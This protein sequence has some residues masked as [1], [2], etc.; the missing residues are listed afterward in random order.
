MCLQRSPRKVHAT[1]TIADAS[2][3]LNEIACRSFGIQFAIPMASGDE[4]LFGIV[5]DVLNQL[6]MK[7][8]VS[9]RLIPNMNIG[10]R[11]QPPIIKCMVKTYV[12]TPQM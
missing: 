3:R 8:P 5:M 12:Q 1:P 4:D 11:L 10:G 6:G 9:F 7:L 2:P